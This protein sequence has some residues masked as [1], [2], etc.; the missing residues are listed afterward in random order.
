MEVGKGR[1]DRLIAEISQPHP[2]RQGHMFHSDQAGVQGDIYIVSPH[3]EL[4]AHDP[5]DPG[6]PLKTLGSSG[7]PLDVLG[8]KFL[9][10][11]EGVSSCLG[12]AGILGSQGKS[13]GTDLT[14]HRPL[15]NSQDRIPAWY[16]YS[17]AH[18]GLA[19]PLLQTLKYCD[20]CNPWGLEPL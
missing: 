2:S 9:H 15:F 17:M 6:P 1:E 12:E 11:L 7:S 16:P 14:G 13:A 10:C 3:H 18:P 4:R 5:H 19:R 8:H 20:P